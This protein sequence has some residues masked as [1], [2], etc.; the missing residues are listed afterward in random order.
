M[1]LGISLL[2]LEL[3]QGRMLVT[4]TNPMLVIP[5]IIHFM[6]AWLR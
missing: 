6:P 5:E 1:Y 2:K 4:V 3:N